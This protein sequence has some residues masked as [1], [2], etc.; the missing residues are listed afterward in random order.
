LNANKLKELNE[1]AGIIVDAAL[2]VHRA[3]GPGL[4]ESAYRAC[5]VHELRSRGLHVDVEVT[6]PI[7]YKGIKLDAGYR[8]DLLV[9]RELVVELKSIAKLLD[10][11]TAQLLSHLR[12]SHRSLGLLINFNVPLLKQGIKR[13]ANSFA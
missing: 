6:L 7:Y 9:E 11:H 12:L 2:H 10:V 13:V 5:L 4:L 1:L 8:I 3:I